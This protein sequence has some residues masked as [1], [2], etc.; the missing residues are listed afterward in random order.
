MGWSAG[1]SCTVYLIHDMLEYN[2]KH[3]GENELPR[4]R[5]AVCTYP[6]T[7]YNFTVNNSSSDFE[8]LKTDDPALW[9][10][11][12]SLYQEPVSTGRHVP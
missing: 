8:K 4:L 2:A 7:D 12:Q 9:E 6:A 10:A 11:I 3:A 1:G 5:A